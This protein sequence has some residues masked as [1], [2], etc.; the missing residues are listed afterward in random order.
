MCDELK[1]LIDELEGCQNMRIGEMTYLHQVITEKYGS[2]SVMT[3][4][5]MEK[6]DKAL[7]LCEHCDK[8]IRLENGYYWSHEG[9]QICEECSDYEQVDDE[10]Y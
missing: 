5:F 2:L 9:E 8:W 7:Y 4:E 6:I 3:P 1:E 10:Y